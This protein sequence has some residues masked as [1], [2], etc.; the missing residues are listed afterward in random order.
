MDEL[1]TSKSST[2]SSASLESVSVQNKTVFK[3]QITLFTVF[4]VF[5]LVLD[6]ESVSFSYT[7]TLQYHFTATHIELTNLKP[8][9]SKYLIVLYE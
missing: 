7:Y 9:K 4:E 6:Q 3:I 5:D 1:P 8:D 2:L